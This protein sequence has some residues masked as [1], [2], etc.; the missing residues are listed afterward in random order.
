MGLVTILAK[1]DESV[2]L[3]RSRSERRRPDGSYLQA[4]D[5]TT[6]ALLAEVEVDTHLHGQPMTYL[7]QGRQYIAVTGGGTE[8]EKAELVVFALPRQ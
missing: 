6:G 7:H 3:W 2:S 4:Y 8:D 5:K 1:V